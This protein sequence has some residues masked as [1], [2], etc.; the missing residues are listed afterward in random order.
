MNLNFIVIIIILIFISVIK[1][2]IIYTY[3][4]YHQ[5]YDRCIDAEMEFIS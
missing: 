2:M 4:D 3:K 1:S 5:S